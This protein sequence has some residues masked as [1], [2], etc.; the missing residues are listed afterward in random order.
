VA[1]GDV[2]WGCAAVRFCDSKKIKKKPP[3]HTR[4]LAGTE[5][6]M[7]ENRM[8]AC[9]GHVR[10]Q[11]H[12]PRLVFN[13]HDYYYYYNYYNNIVTDFGFLAGFRQVYRV[14]SLSILTYTAP[15][16]DLFFFK[17]NHI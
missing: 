10:L 1:G 16:L 2:G 17:K 9:T 12:R 15:S 3:R 4:T 6:K 14:H 13:T 8:T 5:K 7:F 11:D